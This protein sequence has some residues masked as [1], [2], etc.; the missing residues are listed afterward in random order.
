MT[1]DGGKANVMR[2]WAGSPTTMFKKF[3]SLSRLRTYPHLPHLMRYNSGATMV[4]V[5]AKQK[6]LAYFSVC[7][8]T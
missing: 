8:F 7:L 2:T 6:N 1:V 4:L 5:H 3:R